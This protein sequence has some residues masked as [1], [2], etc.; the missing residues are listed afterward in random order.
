MIMILFLAG[1]AIRSSIMILAGAILVSVLRIRDATLRWAG[2]TAMLC[3]SL[4]IPVMSTT[5]PSVNIGIPKAMERP[6]PVVDAQQE[7]V[8]AEFPVAARL[9]ALETPRGATTVQPGVPVAKPFDWGQAILG[10]YSLIG[11]ILLSRVC[12][13]L[14]IS[15]VLL[16]RSLTTDMPGVRESDRINA[17]VTLGIARPSIVLPAGWRDWNSLKLEAVLAHERSHIARC[18]P[19]VQLLSAIHRALLWASPVSWF[20]HQRIVRAAEEASDDAAVEATHDR[21]AYAES[22]L[23]FMKRGVWSSSPAGVPMARYGNPEHR[24]RRI[25]DDGLPSRRMTKR[26]IAAM[27]ALGSPLAYVIATAEPQNATPGPAFNSVEIRAAAPN[28]MPQM[29][30]RFGNGRYELH[31]A[32][33][34]DLIRTAWGV[35]ADGVSGGPDW[36][37]LNRYDVIAMAPATTMPDTL[38]MMLQRMLKD[39]FQ[40]S[41]R[42][43][44]KDNSAYAI[45]IGR[46]PQLKP[47][48]GTE[49]SGCSFQPFPSASRLRMTLVCKNVSIP[50]FAKILSG[51]QEASGY[52]FGYPLLDR[53]GLAGAWNFSLSWSPRRANIWSP[54][55]A[56]I[57][58]L[59]DAFDKQLGLKLV[60]TRVAT[61]VLVVEKATPPRVTDASK[62]DM[63]FEVAEIRP[64]DPNNPAIPCGNINIQPG[65]R[66]RIGMTLRHLIW[67]AWG[68]PF[69]FSRFIGGPKGM[70]S[71]CWQILAKMPVEQNVLG[72]VNPGGWNGAIWNGV[73]LDTMRMSLRSF[74]VDRFKLV[75]HL[76]ARPIDGYVLAGAGRRLRKA[77]PANRPSCKEGPG[78]DGKDPRLTNPLATRLITCRNMTLTRFAEQLNGF[79]PGSPP[80]SDATG[81]S[82]RFDMTI[83]FSPVGLVQAVP[84]E[85]GEAPEPTGAIS[86]FDALK[87]QLG[88]KV[89]TRKLMAP[90]LIVDHVNATPT[91][92]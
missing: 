41:A 87:G 7:P 37:D 33:A 86:L 92:N 69:D 49:A 30:S 4:L 46:K 58:T 32:S 51:A 89:E 19:A 85:S 84:S 17:P 45:T 16:R 54:A 53:T 28:T 91:E 81:I 55:Q 78:D 61:P 14:G 77:N 25:L 79:F 47:S 36:L 65:G 71:P 21:I 1:W 40:L 6:A 73:D 27:V 23:D 68:A 26:S 18:D 2:W 35:A 10:V 13:G 11:A 34:V 62:P 5:L 80:M 66:V 59:F 44:S 60:L 88:L 90:V 22:L 43:G 57:V 8:T 63:E 31:N 76:E 50:A 20:L 83:N 48:E 72:T 70:D 39:R 67:E 56:E 64:E 12:I 24:V 75:A 52:V 82:G 9:G 38:R 29:R 74:L 42:N 15:L 3:G